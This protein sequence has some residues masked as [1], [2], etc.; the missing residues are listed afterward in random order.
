MLATERGFRHRPNS[1]V[2]IKNHPYSPQALLSFKTNSIGYRNREIGPKTGRR[3]LFLG[4]SITFGLGMPEENTFV[5]LVEDQARQRGENW[6]TINSAV[7]GLGMNA[8][9]AILTETGL[10]LQPDLVVLDF[11]LNDFQESPGIYLT[12]LPGILNQSRLA[13]KLTN[14]F[15]SE[16]F[17]L[18][19]GGSFLKLFRA[20]IRGGNPGLAGRV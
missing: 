9:L 20:E 18:S 14:V 5:R 3:I 4:D 2:V 16:S 17:P 15:R 19:G 7:K 11:Y 6:E 1:E 13:H 10:A 12:R 8:E